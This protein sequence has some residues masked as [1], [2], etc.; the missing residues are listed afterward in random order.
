MLCFIRANV[1]YGRCPGPPESGAFLAASEWVRWW[2]VFPLGV[3]SAMANSPWHGICYG[4]LGGLGGCLGLH[5]RYRVNCSDGYPSFPRNG[6]PFPAPANYG[7]VSGSNGCLGFHGKGARQWLP[8]RLRRVPRFPPG[9]GPVYS[10]IYSSNGYFHFPQERDPSMAPTLYN[11]RTSGSDGY[12][13]FPQDGGPSSAPIAAPIDVATPMGAL[14]PM[15][16]EPATATVRGCLGLGGSWTH[17]CPNCS[18]TGCLGSHGQGT[19]YGSDQCFDR[20][21]SSHGLLKTHHSS[22]D[23]SF[24]YLSSFRVKTCLSCPSSSYG[25][26]GVHR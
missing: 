20:C 7:R 22:H 3:E 5:R 16:R 11:G 25:Y 17:H 2:S 1:G 15:A 18:S 23:C 13:R 10:S 21:L 6:E 14:A 12:L 24:G 9:R 8:L 26:H 4:L 19:R